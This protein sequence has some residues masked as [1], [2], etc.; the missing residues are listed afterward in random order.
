MSVENF[1]PEGKSVGGWFR[2]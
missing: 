2:F 1:M